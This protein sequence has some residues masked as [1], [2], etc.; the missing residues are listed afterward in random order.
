M[1]EPVSYCLHN[2]GHSQLPNHG[3]MHLCNRATSQLSIEQIEYIIRSRPGPHSRLGVRDTISSRS[4]SCGSPIRQQG[5]R[6]AASHDFVRTKSWLAAALLPCCRMGLP[7]D[8]DLELM[9]SRTPRREWG[10]GL[11]LM[12]YSICSILSCEVA[13][14]HKCIIP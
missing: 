5:S 8:A 9:V 1:P 13:R 6:A 11:D 14:L 3:I 7:Q 12:I 10:P 4:A 2:A